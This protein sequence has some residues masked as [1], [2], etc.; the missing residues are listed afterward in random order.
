MSLTSSP[1]LRCQPKLGRQ[2]RRRKKLPVTKVYPDLSPDPKP[3]TLCASCIWDAWD[4]L[5][6]VWG[7]FW[8][9]SC[10][11]SVF[12]VFLS[13]M[14]FLETILRTLSSVPGRGSCMSWAKVREVLSTRHSFLSRWP[15]SPLKIVRL[16]DIPVLDGNNSNCPQANY[17]LGRYASAKA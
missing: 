16:K 14:I 3:Q 12:W 9:N 8:V 13:F 6:C 15:S 2:C 1:R 10:M 17:C 11:F 7:E 4:C 5:G